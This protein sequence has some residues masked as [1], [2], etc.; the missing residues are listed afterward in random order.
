MK[1]LLTGKNGQVGYELERAL[2]CV[3]DVTAVDSRQLN[4][5]SPDQVRKMVASIKPDLIVN[6]AAYTAVDM[7]EKYS[8]DA[9][10]VNA[11]APSLLATEARKVG[12]GIIHYSTDYVFDGSKQAP[13]LE[14]DRPCP[15]NVY[16]A[17]KLAGE[18]AIQVS[19]A[20]HLILRTSWVYG[21][22]GKNF[23]LTVLR[24]ARER[25]ELRIV[26]DQFGAPTWSRT[27]A[28][29]TAQVIAQ[30][31]AAPDTAQWWRQKGGVYHVTAQGTT[32]WHGFA[33][34]ILARATLEKVPPVV[35]IA[36]SEYPTPAA[37]PAYSV[38]SNDKFG[39]TFNL[40]MPQ[41]D[42]G[43]GLCMACM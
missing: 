32:T 25:D 27:I 18:Q 22:R 8:V 40:S 33:E 20:P 15:V 42:K 38:L 35:G 6:P 4:L 31:K 29:V 10:Q 3:A 14:E 24:L 23:L 12:A 9:M 7:A 13:Y 5:C 43:L 39:K 16:G 21:L 30:L 34:S 17:S 41:W 1:I 19:G 11:A 37:R 2:Q 28:E 36:T 26:A